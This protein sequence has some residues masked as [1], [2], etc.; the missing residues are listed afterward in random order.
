M[1]AN[2]TT[3]RVASFLLPSWRSSSDSL[4]RRFAAISVCMV[5]SVLTELQ[6][7]LPSAS[8][9]VFA[10]A[11]VLTCKNGLFS[12]APCR[13][14]HPA[15]ETCASSPPLIRNRSLDWSIATLY[16]RTVRDC[17]LL[18][19]R[20]M[21]RTSWKK[22][23]KVRCCS[24]STAVVRP[25]TVLTACVEDND[26][27]SSGGVNLCD[28]KV[29][30][31]IALHDAAPGEV[32]SVLQV[33]SRWHHECLRGSKTNSHNSRSMARKKRATISGRLSR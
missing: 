19:V 22:S 15:R 8:S 2:R 6:F 24:S 14:P 26:C 28:S 7:D 5:S 11:L 27:H 20:P 33:S 3:M 31:P 10:H 16:V 18:S 12:S 17:L 21:D 23:T 30:V 25:G 32:N 29:V 4:T 13:R 9:F 1:K